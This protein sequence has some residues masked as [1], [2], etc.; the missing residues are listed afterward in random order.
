MPLCAGDCYFC[1]WEGYGG[2]ESYGWVEGAAPTPGSRIEDQVLRVFS[3]QEL[4]Q[5]RLRL[6]N[7]KYLVLAGPLSGALR[8]GNGAAIG[9]FFPQS[10]NLFWPA[11]QAWCVAS[12]IDFDSTLVGGSARLIE[13]ILQTPALDAWGVKPDD[14][15][16]DDADKV[17]P[18]G[19]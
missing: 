13:A 18:V 1:L 6:P 12:E 5:P 16:A 3:P 4:N 11:D 8:I 14:S 9:A 17:H 2:L 19:E 10:P 7:R 15:L